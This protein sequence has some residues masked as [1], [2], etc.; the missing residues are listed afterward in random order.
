MFKNIGAKIKKIA[1]IYTIL[2]IVVSVIWGITT[3]AISGIGGLLVIVIGCLA[4]WI[5]SFL[6]YGF[7]QLVENS[8]KLVKALSEK[9]KESDT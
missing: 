3:M 9:N 7:G 5:G 6:L 1:E 2:G 8:D 4:S